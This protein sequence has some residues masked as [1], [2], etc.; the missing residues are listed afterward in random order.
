MKILLLTAYFA[1]HRGGSEIFLENLGRRLFQE[2]ETWTTDVITYNTEKVATEE[3]FLSNDGKKIGTI[4]RLKTWEI[5]RSQFALPNYFQLLGLIKKWQKSKVHYDLVISN[6]RFFDNSQWA[7]KI[8]KIFGAKSI[9]IDHIASH[10][11]GE[12]FLISKIAALADKLISWKIKN[13][14]DLILAITDATKRFIKQ[15]GLSAEQEILYNYVD[16]DFFTQMKTD[17]IS[18]KIIITYAARMIKSK[19]PDLVLKSAAQ[20]VDKYPQVEFW[21]IGDGPRLKKLQRQKES[22]E[23]K[24]KNRIK[25]WGVLDR[26]DLATKLWQSQIFIYPTAHSEGLP[27]TVLEA[28]FCQN[29][30]ITTDKGDLAQIIKN[31][32]T[33]TIIV[34]PTETSVVLALENYLNNPYLITEQAKNLQ[35]LIIE[36]YTLTKTAATFKKI[37][38]EKFP[39][40]N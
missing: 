25:L 9:L 32:K 19:N 17:K 11:Q 36:K 8:A 10:P 30:I 37:V 16:D 18:E 14:Y 24:I 26:L 5:L 7:P 20:I 6:T 31:E 22:F 38:A 2:D 15:L 12:N 34:S 39:N 28:G 4:Y 29:V 33:G 40:L 23:K 3:D 35:R 13:Q 1:P 27:T 21:L